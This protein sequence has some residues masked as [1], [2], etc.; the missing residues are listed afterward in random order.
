MTTPAPQF[1]VAAPNLRGEG[2]RSPIEVCS[3]L[4]V[5]VQVNLRFHF[6]GP[7]GAAY[8]IDLCRS[9][10]YRHDRVRAAI[11][12]SL[13][14][15]IEVLTEG[16][17]CRPR[18]NLLSL[19]PGDGGV[20]ICILEHL[21][22]ALE[23]ATYRCVDFSFELLE[24]AVRRIRASGAADRLPVRAWCANFAEPDGGA[25]RDGERDLVLLTG[26]TLGNDDE[27]RVLADIARWMRP[28]DFLLLD[29]HLHGL[30]GDGER[31]TRE[32][33]GLLLRGYDNPASNRFAFGPVEMVTTAQAHDVAFD[34]RIGRS[35]TVVPG[36]LNVVTGCSG[37]EARLRL[38]GAPVARAHLDLASTTLYRFEEL[39]DWLADSPLRL[40]LARRSG[41]SG[42]F[43]LE[44]PVQ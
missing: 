37:L 29:G 4:D 8:W 36:A 6:S 35:V 2:G 21:R 27:A 15:V 38:T 30:E 3:D 17:R 20:D 11:E 18:F 13:G 23:L 26:Y 1:L 9:Q 19:G 31:L 34:Y 22:P 24:Y 7:L 43:L 32:Q 40:R 10:E 16:G 42:V 33:R 12:S 44:K 39:R 25:W 28:G 5:A 41:E 14:A